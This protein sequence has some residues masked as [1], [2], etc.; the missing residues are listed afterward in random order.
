M[1][2]VLWGRPPWSLAAHSARRFRLFACACCR[3]VMNPFV[4]PLAVRA[5]T[6][7]EAFADGQID[8]DAIA[9]VREVVSRALQAAY[10][11]DRNRGTGYLSR[12]LEGCTSVCT[13]NQRL[14]PAEMAQDVCHA[15]ARA[16]ADVTPFRT[17]DGDS[18]AEYIAE[19]AAQAELLRDIFGN[20]FRG[21]TFDPAWRTADVLALARGMY[22][23]RDFSAM[24]ILADALQDAGCE[25]EDLLNHCREDREHV[26]GCWVVDLVLGK[27]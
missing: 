12:L 3:Q 8:A 26:R 10:R 2:N 25:D 11:E 23:S 6:A 13:V 4:P 16:A 17:E 14:G 20:P 22:D 19:L 7:A 21:V 24:P 15:T 9:A 1:V 18:A 5:V 27:K